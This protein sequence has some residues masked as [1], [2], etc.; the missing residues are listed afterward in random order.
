M[1]YVY[2]F[3]IYNRIGASFWSSSLM[4]ERNGIRGSQVFFNMLPLGGRVMADPR[5][6]MGL[7]LFEATQCEVILRGIS[8]STTASR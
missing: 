3:T 1:I 8:G 2:A 6:D 4:R 5:F 7:Q